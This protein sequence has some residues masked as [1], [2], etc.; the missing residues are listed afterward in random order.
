[1]FE[2]DVQMHGYNDCSISTGQDYTGKVQL[3]GTFDYLCQVERQ[4]FVI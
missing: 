3:H 2:A 4:V 1:M